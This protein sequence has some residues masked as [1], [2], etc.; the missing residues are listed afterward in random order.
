MSAI[1]KALWIMPANKPWQQNSSERRPSGTRERRKVLIVCEDSKSACDYF[2]SF[3]V[4]SSR[5]EVRSLGLGMNTDSLVEEAIN[6]KNQ[7][8]NVSQPY[9]EVW[10]VFD[11]DSFPQENYNRAFARAQVEG[12]KVAWTNEAFEFWY[13]LHF[14]YH[15]TGISRHDYKSKLKNCGLEYDKADT[16]IY[17]Q[18]KDR[19]ALACKHA[20]KLERHWNQLGEHFPERRNPSTSVH[21]LVEFLNDLA[22]LGSVE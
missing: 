15:D 22:D 1:C 11:R 13:L 12:I 8:A 3:P 14:N 21:K 18:M 19:Q 6:L 17:T 4:E 2:K 9:N 10:C 5:A 16:T 7:A 20:A